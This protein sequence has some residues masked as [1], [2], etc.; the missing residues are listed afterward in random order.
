MMNISGKIKEDW[1]RNG[2]MDING[3]LLSPLESLKANKSSFFINTF[4]NPYSYDSLN[5]DPIVMTYSEFSIFSNYIK[6]IFGIDLEE[7]LKKKHTYIFPE[8]VQNEIKYEMCNVESNTNFKFK[9][10]CTKE[11]MEKKKRDLFEFIK[12]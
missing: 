9:D 12:M 7:E 6:K 10:E 5:I 4:E 2:L 3:N 1:I 11:K 8:N